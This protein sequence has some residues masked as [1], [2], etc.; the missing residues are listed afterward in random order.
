MNHL[1]KSPL[2]AAVLVGL[3]ALLA[4]ADT[5]QLGRPGALNYVEGTVSLN[6]RTVGPKAV[7]TLDLDPGQVLETGNGR[8]EILLTP[9]VFLRLGDQSALKMISPSLTDTT[10]ELQRGEALVEVDQVR[11]ENHLDV[12]DH[13]VNTTLVKKGIYSFDAS[14]PSVKVY[15]GKAVVAVDDRQIEVKKGKELPLIAQAALKPEKFDRNNEDSLYAWSKLRSEYMAE[16][17][18]ASAQTIIAE[19][20]GWYYGTGWYWNP[21]FDSWA[22][23]PGAGYIYNPFGF[24][25]YSP[26]YF[27]YAPPVYYHG[28][29]GYRG[30]HGGRYYGGF[31]GLHGG[32]RG[33]GGRPAAPAPL[34]GSGVHFGGRR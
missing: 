29:G 12:V 23:V 31:Q 28:F 4:M 11:K 9:G 15:D 34:G 26:G 18:A 7:G 8:A 16:A 10:V 30:F 27:Y 32:F 24:G 25:F 3:G 22:F 6:G 13:G 20:P 1:W 19:N 5:P 33:T 21:W 14:Q 2:R 17:N